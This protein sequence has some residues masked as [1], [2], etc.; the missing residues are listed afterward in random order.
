MSGNEPQFRTV[1]Q[2]L[3]RLPSGPA[4]A[5]RASNSMS[6]TIP[7]PVDAILGELQEPRHA[8]LD[9]RLP[10]RAAPWH[11]A[12]GD[13]EVL[14]GRGE[15]CTVCLPLDSVSRCH[16]RIRLEDEEYIIEDLASTNGTFV[17]NVRVKQC[18]LRHNDQVRIGE[19]L[20]LFT[21]QRRS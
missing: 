13:G 20:I 2:A 9:I 14:V 7:I 19:T 12:L 4:R 15:D 11:I 5:D 21:Q 8:S 10:G 18:V 16:A 17:N 3:S 6:S 1:K